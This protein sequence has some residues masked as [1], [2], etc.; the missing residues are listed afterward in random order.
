MFSH[1]SSWISIWVSISLVCTELGW[2]DGYG[3]GW[4]CGIWV[5]FFYNVP[6]GSLLSCRE[7][8]LRIEPSMIAFILI[9]LTSPCSGNT[10]IQ[11]GI[12][13]PKDD[14]R[15]IGVFRKKRDK[16][17]HL[18]GFVP[19]TYFFLFDTFTNICT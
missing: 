4:G 18:L 9:G 19:H 11:Y 13:T 3:C 6:I 7:I 17:G 2:V 14:S 8:V 10:F 16:N 15:A 12:W 1:V 5:T